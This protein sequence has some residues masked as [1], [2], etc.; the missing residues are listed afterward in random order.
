MGLVLKNDR[1]YPDSLF[2]FLILTERVILRA[3]ITSFTVVLIFVL[4]KY[5]GLF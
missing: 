4:M 2:L 5:S 3:I 1:D